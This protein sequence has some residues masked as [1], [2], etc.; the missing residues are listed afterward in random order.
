MVKYALKE[1]PGELRDGSKTNKLIF[2]FKDD[3]TK[4]HAIQNHDENVLSLFVFYLF[5]F[6]FPDCGFLDALGEMDAEPRNRNQRHLS[7]L[8][9]IQAIALTLTAKG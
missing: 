3:L 9:T 2:T 5:T 7:R 1:D 6:T 8:N 4:S